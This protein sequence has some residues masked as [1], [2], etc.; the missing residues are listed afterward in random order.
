MKAGADVTKYSRIMACGVDE[1][2][3]GPWAGPVVAAAVILDRA[4]PIEGLDDSKR[5]T[6]RVRERLFGEII[7]SATIATA[8]VGCDR[9]ERLNIRGAS[10]YAM[11]RAI[12]ALAVAPDLA[13]IDGNAL[14][15]GLAIKARALVKGDQRSASV[16]A[17]SI[18]AKVT[19]DRLMVHLARSCPGYGF[20]AHKGYG[21]E[22]HRAALAR[23]GPSIHHR[24]GF[25]PVRAAL[26]AAV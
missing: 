20:E 17:A 4:R 9:I 10:L 24:R 3:R 26:A 12:N 23:L 21:T 19:R 5:L 11:T 15:P 2:G 16:A 18:V 6:A 22:Q 13:L 25:A 7:D 8:I 14:P 1:A